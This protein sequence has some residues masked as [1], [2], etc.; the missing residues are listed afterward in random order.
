MVIPFVCRVAGFLYMT[1]LLVFNVIFA[2]N[3]VSNKRKTL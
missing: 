3:F 1:L 2:S